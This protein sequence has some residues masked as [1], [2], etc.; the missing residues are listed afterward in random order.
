MNHSISILLI[1]FCLTSITRA[2]E[3]DE[4][5]ALRLLGKR[6][7]EAINSGELSSIS[8]SVLP[9]ASAIFITGEEFIGLEAMQR[10]FDDT[11]K[12]LGEGSSFKIKLDPD[13]TDFYG[14]T[15]IAHGRSSE[16]IAFGNGKSVDYETRWTAVLIKQDDK[17]M[18]SRLHVSMSA[19]DNPIMNLKLAAGKWINIGMGLIGGLIL[20]WLLFKVIKRK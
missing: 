7:E 9:T 19:I 14:N 11:K 12:M 1:L 17:W 10:F 3:N 18:A 20:A 13:D 8:D 16:S 4:K 6:Y 2:D 5:N 15:A